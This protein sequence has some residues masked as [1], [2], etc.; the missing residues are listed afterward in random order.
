MYYYVLYIIHTS[1]VLCMYVR[2]YVY[3]TLPVTFA[4]N[5]TVC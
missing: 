3:A 5:T 1:H 2:T 4:S